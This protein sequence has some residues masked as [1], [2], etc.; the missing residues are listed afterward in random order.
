MTFGFDTT[1]STVPVA[2][3]GPV[4]VV[5]LELL[6]LAGH[7]ENGYVV[8]DGQVKNVSGQPAGSVE[9]VAQ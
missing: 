8:V 2:M 4:P 6:A 3:V 7:P 5:K 9:A 1:R